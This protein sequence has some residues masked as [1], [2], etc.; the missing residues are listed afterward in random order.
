MNRTSP[1]ILIV[2]ALVVVVTAGFIFSNS[3]QSTEGSWG[4]S[5]IVAALFEPVLRR[6]HSAFTRLIV[7]AGH[8]VVLEYGVFVRKMAHFTEYFALGVECTCV[9]SVLTKRALSPYLWADLFVVLAVAVVDEFV[10][11][12][13]G[14]TSQVADVLLDF[15]G[16]CA[17]IVL[18]LVVA[19]LVLRRFG[20]RDDL[21]TQRTGRLKKV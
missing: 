9:I 20:K 18:T 4:T 10:Q 1:I 5:N 6:A 3:M 8:P 16:A 14:R 12:F 15:S 2:M 19:S 17:G 13:V 21:G 11:S 7:L